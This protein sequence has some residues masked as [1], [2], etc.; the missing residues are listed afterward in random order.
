MLR[1]PVPA[2]DWELLA[3]MEGTLVFHVGVDAPPWSAALPVGGPAP[4]GG[5]SQRR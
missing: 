2:L 5:V 1:G 3:R 4:A